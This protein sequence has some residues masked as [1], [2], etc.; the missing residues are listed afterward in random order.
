MRLWDTGKQVDRY[1]VA[2]LS[3]RSHLLSPRQIHK[4]RTSRDQ[5]KSQSKDVWVQVRFTW[6]SRIKTET[7]KNPLRDHLSGRPVIFSSFCD[8]HLQTKCTFSLN[9]S[10]FKADPSTQRW[11]VGVQTAFTYWV[12]GAGDIL[13]TY[14]HSC[15]SR[16]MHTHVLEHETASTGTLSTLSHLA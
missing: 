6:E 3:W 8:L 10:F 2:V 7:E 13:W 4:L 1:I 15:K 11:R 12:A 5:N 9:R 14:R 16:S